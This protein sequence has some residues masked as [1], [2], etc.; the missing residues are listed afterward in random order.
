MSGNAT[1][2]ALASH[3]IDNSRGRASF[4]LTRPRSADGR[5]RTRATDRRTES[6][7]GSG[8]DKP[9]PPRGP[10]GCQSGECANHRA[11]RKLGARRRGAV[12][13]LFLRVRLSRHHPDDDQPVPGQRRS[14]VAG[15]PASVPVP[16]GYSWSLVASSGSTRPCRLTA[17]YA[18]LTRCC[19]P[20]YK[21]GKKHLRGLKGAA[22]LPR[23]RRSHRLRSPRSG[24]QEDDWPFVGLLQVEAA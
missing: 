12:S 14:L 16:C 17:V 7:L 15:P 23:D 10:A 6:L 24:Y 4:H 11:C 13:R 20:S 5:A 22:L 18:R 19:G 3:H 2:A 21:S 8:R 9:Q 1:G